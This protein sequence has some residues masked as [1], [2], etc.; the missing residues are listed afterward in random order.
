[1][2]EEHKE[3]HEEHKPR[4][5][6]KIKLSKLDIIAII[7]LVIVVILVTFPTYVSKGDCEVARADFKCASFKEVLIENCDYWSEYDC[8]TDADISLPQIESYIKSLCELE[9]SYHNT[10]LDCSN[11]KSACN[12]ITGKQTCPLGYL[13]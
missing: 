6:P 2:E 4:R 1:M 8:N 7:V 10:G 3:H 13:G 5:F 11:L 9:N 12:E